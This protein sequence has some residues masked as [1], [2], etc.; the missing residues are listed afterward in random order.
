LVNWN[1]GFHLS[2]KRFLLLIVL[3]IFTLSACRALSINDMLDWILEEEQ[4]LTEASRILPETAGYQPGKFYFTDCPFWQ[5]SRD[6]VRCGNLYV[7]EA[8]Y[9]ED[10][11]LIKLAVVILPSVNAIAEPDPILYLSGG[12]G[13]SAISEVGEWLRSPL[14]QEREIVLLDQRGTGY[15]E[16]FLGCPE[17]V[18]MD[19][20]EDVL[21]L[22]RS[23]RNRLA[24]G[25]VNLSAYHSVAS[26]ADIHQLRLALGY[27]SWNLLGVSYGSRLALTVMRDFPEGIRSVVLDSVYPPNANAYTEQPYH[28]AAALQSLFDGCAVDPACRQVYPNLEQVFYSLTAELDSDPIEFDDGS[29]WD[30]PGLIMDI[31]DLLYDSS[32]ISFLPYAMYEASVQNYDPLLELIDGGDSLDEEHDWFE[33][34]ED[35]YES[36]G[37][38]YAVECFESVAFGDTEAAWD[39]LNGFPDALALPLFYDLEEM[40]SA[41]EVWNVGTA[42]EI[43]TQA[44]ISPI[45]TLVLAGEYD[46]VTPPAWARLAGTTLIN[47]KYFEL[48][49]GG[50]ALIDAGPCMLEIIHHFINDPY[51]EPDG[52]CLAPLD[53]VLP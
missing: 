25:G 4:D 23:C 21:E 6:S 16:P 8:Y 51:S 38:F 30:G 35:L 52:A 36:D 13:D 49:R 9:Q 5:P 31:T 32:A 1:K 29:L 14:R 20:D 19:W 15:S 44:V 17:L 3:F 41:C 18:D 24:A 2:S 12:P 50:H 26:A 48:P 7:R 42:K 40:H 45:P 33:F 34:D 28:I 10:S 22:L 47:H 37:A 46:P 53:F 43:T 11:P 27:E 39:L